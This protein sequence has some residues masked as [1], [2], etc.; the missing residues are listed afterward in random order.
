M[1]KQNKNQKKLNKKLKK[2]FIE[3][4]LNWLLGAD[5]KI[6]EY[7]SLSGLTINICVWKA[8]DIG[9]VLNVIKLPK[10]NLNLV[11]AICVGTGTVVEL[12]I[13]Q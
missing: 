8:M 9:N 11:N 5:I 2:E 10:L 4:G 7:L 13:K 1:F 3:K 12:L 6:T